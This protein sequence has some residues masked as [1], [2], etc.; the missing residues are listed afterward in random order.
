MSKAD[1]HA[2]EEEALFED[3]KKISELTNEMLGRDFAEVQKLQREQDTT[4]TTLKAEPPSKEDA[5]LVECKANDWKFDWGKSLGV[6]FQ[7]TVKKGAP[8]YEHYH[9]L[10][11]EAKKEWR[12]NWAKKKWETTM[13]K[14]TKTET[15]REVDETMGEMMP[16]A[17]VIEQ[18]GF[19][20]DPKGAVRRGVRYCRKCFRLG[21]RWAGINPMHGEVEVLFLHRKHGERLETSWQ[22]YQEALHVAAPQPQAPSDTPASQHKRAKNAESE[23]PPAKV[24]KV[25][26]SAKTEAA[27]HDFKNLDGQVKVLKNTYNTTMSQVQNVKEQ[28]EQGADRYSFA[29]NDQNLGK[30][31]RTVA[32][33]NEVLTD[34]HRK[35]LINTTKELRKMFSES[36]LA[37]E[38]KKFIATM[39]EPMDALKKIVTRIIRQA[40]L[41]D[42]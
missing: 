29:N 33:V 28:I 26:K 23:T 19:W 3:D 16:P 4:P 37:E 27:P 25:T 22:L 30:L 13:E 35:I 1:L 42:D 10:S 8:D 2:S 40:N 31:T 17:R 6:R 38:Y 34:T 14:K 20:S 9:K 5:E 24:P 12:A 7:K 18:L 32:S 36:Y 11:Q 21:G 15:W 41:H 39:T